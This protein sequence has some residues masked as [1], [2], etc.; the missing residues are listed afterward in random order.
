[1]WKACTTGASQSEQWNK[2]CGFVFLAKAA[3]DMNRF[4][5]TELETV[6]S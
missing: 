5:R 2:I 3:K 4:L 6:R 1:M